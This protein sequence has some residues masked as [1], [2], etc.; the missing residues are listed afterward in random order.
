MLWVV[1]IW[2][3]CF[4]VFDI[5][6]KNEIRVTQITKVSKTINRSEEI[7]QIKAGHMIKTAVGLIKALKGP[8]Q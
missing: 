4:H 8:K 1:K 2:G 6:F 7:G 5:L 3:G